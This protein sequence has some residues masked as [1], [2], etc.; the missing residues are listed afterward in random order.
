MDSLPVEIRNQLARTV[1]AARR[2]GEAGARNALAVL[3]VGDARPHPSLSADEQDLRRRLRAHGRQLGDRLD[4]ETGVQQV[5][6]LAHEVAYEHWHRMLFARFLAEND[7]LIEPESGVA[8]SL[9][10]CEE[11]A[12][13]RGQDCWTVAGRFAERMLPRIFRSDAPALAVPL[14]PETRQA[15]ER[16]LESLPAAVFAARDSLGW[17]YQFWQAERKEAVNK[18]GV[19]I[20]ADE[21]PAVTQ[22]FTER[23]MVLFLLHNTVGAWRAGRILAAQPELAAAA[24]S[25]DE[26]RRAVRLEAAGG[27]DF[28]YLRFVREPREDDEEEQPTGPWRPAAGTFAGWPRSAAD[29]RVLDPCCGSGHFLVECLDLLARL[30]MDEERLAPGA[31]VEAVLRDNLFGLEIDPRCTQI[32]AFNLALA[33]WTWPGVGGHRPLPALNLA[34]SGLAPNATRDDWISMAEAA[35]DAGG[36]PARRDLLGVD[37]SLMPA[38]LRNSLGALHD[39]FAQAPVLGSLID[40]RSLQAD[41]FQHDYE[42]VGVLLGALLEQEGA[43]DEHTERVVAAHGIARAA[44]LLSGRYHLLITN[45]PFLG[46]RDQAPA[47]KHFAEEHHPRATADLATLFVSRN[48]RCLERHGVQAAVTPHNWLSLT[49]YRKFRERLLKQRTWNLVAWLGPGAFETIGGHVVNVALSVLTAQRPTRNWRMA[50]IDVSASR[51]QQSMRPEIKAALLRGVSVDGGATYAIHVTAQKEQLRNPDARVLLVPTKDADTLAR[52][53]QSFQGTT[54]GDNPRFVLAF[55][56]TNWTNGAWRT[57]QSTGDEPEHFAGR[58]HVF[59]W[60]DGNGCVASSHAARVQGQVAWNKLGI[61]VRQMGELSTTLN[62]GSPWDMN[63]ATIVPRDPDHLSAI[64]CYCSSPDYSKAVRRIDQHLKVT[65]A[66]LVKVPFDVLRW[67]QVAEERYPKGLPE[68]FSNDPSQW[69]FHGHPCG[70]VVWDEETKGTTDG[71]I[72]IDGVVLQ[73]AVARLLGY[74]WPAED[75]TE[76]RLADEARSWVE[77]SRDLAE[78]ADADGIVCLASV[79]SERAAADRVRRVLAAAYGADWS[80]A[81]ERRL[82]AAAAG[83][84]QA[85]ESIEAWLWDRF[86]KEHCQRFGQRPF[87]WHVWDG[88]RDGFH[89]LVNYHRLAGPNGEG[90]RTLEALAYRHLGEWIAR[91]RADR[92]LGVDGADGRLAAAQEL[93]NQLTMIR[94]GDPPCDLFVRWKPL[95]EQPIGW[96]PDLNDGVRINIRPFMSAVLTRGGRAGAGV[97]RVKPK[98][99][100]SK[101][102]GK[103]ALQRRKPRRRRWEEDADPNAE[104]NQDRELRPRE[105]YPWFWGCP[106]GGTEAERTDFAGGPDFDG[107]RWNDL[108]YT[109]AA[110]RAARSQKAIGVG[111]RE[112]D[113]R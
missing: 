97:L 31:A 43:N 49:S 11:L 88:R 57:L 32:A 71:P 34:C 18:S 63:C 73:V 101:D 64:W 77:R 108:H 113:A 107:N 35:A 102:P 44:E 45:V 3:A 20:G 75:E 48:L 6:R 17:T 60:E 41:L 25:E 1:Q 86:F 66:T 106:G 46:R 84:G 9:T 91:Q 2:T 95:A 40:P 76:M 78:L 36:L 53:A 16:L 21:L 28:S 70:S 92:D 94:T 8:V 80:P 15:L 56:E 52:Y 82:L 85:A 111:A 22:L 68:P 69:I 81:T 14:A 110:K 83:N 4:A 74:R 98:L 93:Q 55:W 112:D 24:A 13:E 26:L 7:L 89:A 61:A 87:V 79:A 62:S 30:R 100:W 47:L 12:R 51:R 23:Y 72:R 54:T 58:H 50:G 29:L 99:A 10:D 104:T 5:D 33:A 19:K 90:R 105:E 67:R 27:Y 39:L 42:S 103:E 59:L 37:D 96:E 109:N 65:N 38:P